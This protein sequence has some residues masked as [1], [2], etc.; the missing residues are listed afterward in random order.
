MASPATVLVVDDD[1]DDRALAVDILGDEGFAVVEAQNGRV[2]L[3]YLLGAPVLPG[4]ILADLNMPVMTGWEMITVARSYLRFSNL[5]IVVVTGESARTP[6]LDQFRV[7]RLLK[8]YQP[9]DLLAIVRA[10]VR[11]EKI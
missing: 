8:P 7:S 9:D 4:L 1:S 10:H 11:P 2:A 3:D 6:L 5:P